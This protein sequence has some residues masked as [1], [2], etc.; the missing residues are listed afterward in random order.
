MQ[1]ID[2]VIQGVDG[3]PQEALKLDWLVFAKE[4]AGEWKLVMSRFN[5]AHLECQK[6]AQDVV[7]SCFR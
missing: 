1:A 7:D 2:A 3:L 5:A 4:H 6:A